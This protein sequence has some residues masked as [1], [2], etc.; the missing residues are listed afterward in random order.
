MAR[1]D[2]PS[3][4]TKERRREQNKLAQRRFRRPQDLLDFSLSSEFQDPETSLTGDSHHQNYIK[5]PTTSATAAHAFDFYERT[6]PLGGGG[7]RVSTHGLPDYFNLTSPDDSFL[8]DLEALCTPDLLQQ[9]LTPTTTD[10][11]TMHAL[12]PFIRHGIPMITPEKSNN[13]NSNSSSETGVAIS[14][15]DIALMSPDLNLDGVPARVSSPLHQAVRRGHQRIVQILLAHQAN[16]NEKDE[17]GQTPLVHAVLGGHKEVADLL[18]AHGAQIGIVDDEHRSALH[19]AVLN[20]QDRLLKR[21]LRHCAGESTAIDGLTRE[22]KTP[23]L[24]AIET[25]F[26]V[27]VEMLLNAGADVHCKGHKG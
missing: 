17:E 24:L 5:L 23:L 26:E 2:S 6:S 19:W 21:L 4:E 15:Q 16:C 20:G 12:T 27:A 14:S 22:G 18:L 8:S 10:P 13:G 7:P 11:L 9:D 3:Q 25:G 1:N